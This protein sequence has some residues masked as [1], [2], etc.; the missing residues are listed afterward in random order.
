MSACTGAPDA[1]ASAEGGVAEAQREPDTLTNVED[2]LPSLDL[3]L[4]DASCYQENIYPVSQLTKALGQ[5]PYLVGPSVYGLAPYSWRNA[6]ANGSV[7]TY[8]DV[9]SVHELALVGPDG[10]LTDTTEL[11]FTHTEDWE[12]RMMPTREVDGALVLTMHDPSHESQ[13]L[14]FRAKLPEMLDAQQFTTTREGEETVFLRWD[15]YAP[16]M[17]AN[18]LPHQIESVYVFAQRET[19]H[20][21]TYVHDDVRVS[22]KPSQLED[23][24]W[25]LGITSDKE[26]Q[27]PAGSLFIYATYPTVR[28]QSDDGSR[29]LAVRWTVINCPPAGVAPS[30]D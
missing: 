12:G 10:A 13:S 27:I 4:A 20:T 25:I 16:Y 17:G 3:E 7:D 21:S 8:W 28:I 15:D 29:E 14:Q 22:R 23:G 18:E 30:V 6:Q 19:P 11:Q 5:S 24:K 26:P 2:E 9:E 1:D